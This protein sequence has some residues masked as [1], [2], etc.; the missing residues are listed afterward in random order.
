[1]THR[2]GTL[3]KRVHELVSRHHRE[4][5]FAKVDDREREKRLKKRRN[6]TKQ[7]DKNS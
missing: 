2:K 4:G 6:G 1:M 5:Q 7:T 3:F